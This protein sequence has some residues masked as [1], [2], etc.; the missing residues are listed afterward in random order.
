[1]EDEIVR[2]LIRDHRDN[3][4]EDRNEHD[5]YFYTLKDKTEMAWLDLDERTFYINT[6]FKDNAHIK[7]LWREIKKKY[8]DKF[9]KESEYFN[10]KG[11]DF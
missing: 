7:N 8:A 5:I 10:L 4:Y 6:D 11:L 3:F 9:D 1:M 2:I